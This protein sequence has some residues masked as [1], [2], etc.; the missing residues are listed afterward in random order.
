MHTQDRE[1]RFFENV[2]QHENETARGGKV[3]SWP[4]ASVLETLERHFAYMTGLMLRGDA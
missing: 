1:V 3:P 4:G 2:R